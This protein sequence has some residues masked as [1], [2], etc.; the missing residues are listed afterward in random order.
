MHLDWALFGD[1]ETLLPAI[2][3]DIPRTI[4]HSEH[5]SMR[6]EFDC[7]RNAYYKRSATQSKLLLHDYKIIVLCK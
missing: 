1:P 3:E 4:I 6:G 2:Y 7:N 5:S